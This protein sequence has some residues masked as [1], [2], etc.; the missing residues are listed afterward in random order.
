MDKIKRH[1][2]DLNDVFLIASADDDHG[3]LYS[4]PISFIDYRYFPFSFLDL[5]NLYNEKFRGILET[6]IYD[7]FEELFGKHGLGYQIM[8]P[9]RFEQLILDHKTKYASLDEGMNKSYYIK[10]NR[11]ITHRWQ[12]HTRAYRCAWLEKLSND[13]E[14]SFSIV[15]EDVNRHHRFQTE[16]DNKKSLKDFFSRALDE[17]KKD[18]E[19]K[20]LRDSIAYKQR[21]RYERGKGF[22]GIYSITGFKRLRDQLYPKTSPD[23]F[24]IILDDYLKLHKEIGTPL[25]DENTTSNYK[26]NLRRLE[27]M[28]RQTG[29]LKNLWHEY[30]A[31]A[32]T[33]YRHEG[34][35]PID[36]EAGIEAYNFAS[37]NNRSSLLMSEQEQFRL[38][39]YFFD[40]FSNDADWKEKWTGDKHMWVPKDPYLEIDDRI[41]FA[42]CR[43]ATQGYYV[44]HPI[45]LTLQITQELAIYDNLYSEK[46]DVYDS[47]KC[48]DAFFQTV[49]FNGSASIKDECYFSIEE[50]K[51]LSEIS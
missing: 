43:V 47:P 21:L 5:N 6:E 34:R 1:I 9:D 24:S 32:A 11:F 38:M 23:I 33:I 18:L 10:L 15:L 13:Y 16:K 22:K 28:R 27:T 12:L 17:S 2:K 4:P 7:D 41:Y 19:D 35:H 36:P 8:Y 42:E 37:A 46:R 49:F 26:P 39:L 50:M 14:I 20:G 3:F 40:E 51:N 29:G 45:E 30:G 44:E 48:L 25:G 31:L